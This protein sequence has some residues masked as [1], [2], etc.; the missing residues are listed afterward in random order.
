VLTLLVL[1]GL[2][3]TGLAGCTAARNG[4]GTHVSLCFRVLPEAQAAVGKS[5]RFAGVLSVPGGVLTAA[6][7]HQQPNGP[8]PAPAPLAAVSH[9]ATCLVAFRGTF[10]L[11]GVRH[12]WAPFAGPYLNAIVVVLQSNSELVA[13]VLVH[14]LPRVL[15][16]FET[17]ALV[18]KSP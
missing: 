3:C 1:L 6:I 10:S 16:F 4:L 12:G 11:S 18:R 13:T 7:A 2:G 14:R 17:T 15:A 9:K 5:S 8:P